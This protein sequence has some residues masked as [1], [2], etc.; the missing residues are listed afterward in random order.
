MNNI[1][2]IAKNLSIIHNVSINVIDPL[3]GDTLQTHEGHNAATY[4]LLTGIGKYLVGNDGGTLSGSTIARR[5]L[6]TY[7]PEYM[8]LGVMGLYGQ[9]SDENGLPTQIGISADISPYENYKAYMEQVPG[10]GADGYSK[11]NNNNRAYFGLGPRFDKKNN[12]TSNCELISESNPNRTKISYREVVDS[13]DAELPQTIDVVFSAMISTGALK[14]FRGDNNYI[15]ITEAGLWSTKQYIDSD[16]P[17]KGFNGLLAGY[18]IV[19]PNKDNWDMSIDTNREILRQN[20]LRV[21]I[22]QVVQVVWK[23]QIGSISDFNT[24]AVAEV[25]RWHVI[26]TD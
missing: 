7:T 22:N 5:L 1:T 18:R 8:S 12:V 13:S 10:F 17:T 23:I 2:E 14:E 21:G 24:I 9:E 15:F 11:Y 4:S 20:I 6:D 19:P 26:S 16:D 25:P 3:T